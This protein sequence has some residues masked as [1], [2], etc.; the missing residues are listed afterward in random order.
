MGL[1]IA[2]A[3]AR[4]EVVQAGALSPCRFPGEMEF[5]SVPSPPA[6]RLALPGFRGG[7]GM[8]SISGSMC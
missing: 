3:Q 7:T 5:R 4:S 1:T 2:L 6:S 8:S